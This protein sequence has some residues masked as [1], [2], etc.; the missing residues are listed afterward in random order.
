MPLHSLKNIDTAFRQSRFLLFGF[1]S[2]ASCLSM[3]SIYA[4][5]QAI[6]KH[7]ETIYVFDQG[8]ILQA[9]ARNVAENRPVEAREHI[10]RFHEYFFTL[11]PDEKAIG[12]TMEKALF[13]SDESVKKQ[14]DNLKEKGFYNE[15]IAGN[16][17]QN[18]QID[19]VWLDVSVYP[20]YARCMGR[21]EI[22]RTSS[23]TFRNLIAECYLRD[24]LRSD[25]NPH[26]FLIERWRVLK[27]D[28]IKTISR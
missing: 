18:I 8:S 10:R 13:L 9:K 16:I 5:R 22:I 27:N 17:S 21:I 15:I 28:D 25:N 1:L 12:A 6:N 3:Y 20:Y 14:Y 19:S 11:S 7:L 23:V 24:V 2:F 26:G 4:S